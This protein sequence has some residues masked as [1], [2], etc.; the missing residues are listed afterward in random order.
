MNM[1]ASTKTKSD[2]Q[3]LSA[4][5]DEAE[6]ELADATPGHKWW[7]E[8]ELHIAKMA[9]WQYRR[10][11]ELEPLMRWLNRTE[12]HKGD[13]DLLP[14]LARAAQEAAEYLANLPDTTTARERAD[15]E[16]TEER[17]SILYTAVSDRYGLMLE[18]KRQE[19]MEN[20]AKRKR[21]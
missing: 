9:Y 8:G 20:A 21:K 13:T 4:A 7:A 11:T 15:A 3:A 14:R 1:N 16:L 6:R 18:Q 5:L 10:D 12:Y 2:Q 19:P 17:A